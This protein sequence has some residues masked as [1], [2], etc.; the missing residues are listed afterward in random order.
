MNIGFENRSYVVYKQ[1]YKNILGQYIKKTIRDRILDYYN[2]RE[3]EQ[4]LDEGRT[5]VHFTDRS[6]A[7]RE[8]LYDLKITVVYD[9]FTERHEVYWESL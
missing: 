2:F 9:R 5:P 4:A 6:K 1:E 8:Y 7:F 3:E